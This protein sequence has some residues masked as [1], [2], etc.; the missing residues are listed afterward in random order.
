MA[1]KDKLV[2]M[3]KIEMKILRLRHTRDCCEV[4]GRGRVRDLVFEPQNL[5]ISHIR[6]LSG[7]QGWRFKIWRSKTLEAACLHMLPLGKLEQVQ[8]QPVLHNESSS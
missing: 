5:P 1:L 6:V 7:V 8:G 3:T 2:V 4:R